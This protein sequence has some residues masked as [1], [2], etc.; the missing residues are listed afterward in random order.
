MTDDNPPIG[1]GPDQGTGEV[2][3]PTSDEGDRK[4]A[5]RRTRI[6]RR[7]EGTG[8]PRGFIRRHKALLAL[9]VILLVIAGFAGGYLWKINQKLDSIP[10]VDAD[11]TPAPEKEQQ[12][13]N[14]P[15][16]ILLLGADHGNV[17]Q[18]VAE[19]LEDGEWTQGAHL[20]DTIILVHIPADRQSV[21]LVS[22]PRDT[23]TK[24]EG[25]PSDN[26][27][28]KINAAFSYGG[29]ALAVKTVEGLTGIT[30]DHLAIIDWVGFKDLTTALGGVRVYIPETFEDESQNVTWKKGWETLEGEVA[31]QYVRTRYGLDDGD[32]GRIARQQNF[33]RATMAK[34]LSGGTTRN[35]VQI[36]KVV[37]VIAEY[38][39]VDD[40]WDTREIRD[41][42]LGM[43]SIKTENVE[44]LTAPL[45][46][47]DTSRDGQS[48]VRLAP[49][50]SDALFAAITEEDISGYLAKYPDESLDDPTSVN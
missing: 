40:S 9:G 10:R 20:S 35:P 17:G 2:V 34:L 45:G 8:R 6:G 16:N 44:F 15:L 22:I 14:H 36:Y 11:I 12:E 41:L 30:I 27:R 4:D 7:R 23:W 49:K 39:T 29:P 26:G 1:Q 18:S 24:I 21:Q 48:I 5:A 43:R 32:F 31:L 33:M 3:D 46:R 38:L 37:D 47:Y 42:A 25:Y 50:Q 13:E 28:A 19:D